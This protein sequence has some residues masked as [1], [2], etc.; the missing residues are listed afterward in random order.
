M[1][2]LNKIIVFLI[3]FIFGNLGVSQSFGAPAAAINPT[4]SLFDGSPTA[5]EDATAVNGTY[6]RPSGSSYTF[7]IK[8]RQFVASANATTVRIDLDLKS[9]I[10][11]PVEFT[12]SAAAAPA[13]GVTV[14]NNVTS[15]IVQFAATA[16]ISPAAVTI[17]TIT[18]TPT[19]GGRYKLVST[20]SVTSGSDTIAGA[21]EL[22]GT[23]GKGA[24]YFSGTG[25]ITAISGRGTTT[26]TAV[27]GGIAAFKF[28]TILN[29]NTEEYRLFTSGY[30]SIIS[31]SNGERPPAS[32]QTLS[33]VATDYSQGVKVIT[34]ADGTQN[35]VTITANSAFVG[36][37]QIYWQRITPGTLTPVT[38]AIAT[39][40]WVE[41]AS[42]A[43]SKQFSHVHINTGSVLANATNDKSTSDIFCDALKVGV[44]CANI[45]LDL[46]DNLNYPLSMS[47][48]SIV[49]TGPGMA[50]LD[51]TSNTNSTVAASG[52]GLSAETITGGTYANQAV[53]S[54]WPDGTTGI[55][56]FT[57]SAGNNVVAERS[58]IFYG[59]PNSIKVIKQNLSIAAA[60]GTGGVLGLASAN[61]SGLTVTSTPAVTLAVF[62]EKGN[63]VPGVTLEAIP[64]DR[65]V[66]SS[67]T[68]VESNGT[69]A[70]DGLAGPGYYNVSVTP[71]TNGESGS[72]SDVVFRTFISSTGKYVESSPISFSLGGAVDEGSAEF[73]IDKNSFAPGEKAKLTVSLKDKYGYPVYDQDVNIF[74]KSG[75]GPV[76]SKQAMGTLPTNISN[77]KYINGVHVYE[78]YAPAY[79]G[80]FTF[81]AALDPNYSITISPTSITKSNVVGPQSKLKEKIQQLKDKLLIASKKISTASDSAV[82][83]SEKA[84]I[85]KSKT[86]ELADSLKSSLA[87]LEKQLSTLKKQ[88][89][90]I[91]KKTKK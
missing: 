25:G 58:I 47:D 79:E 52:R 41:K 5:T 4:I 85:T 62:D 66:I 67:A 89:I 60:K 46:R 51:A 57:I 14:T 74:D 42:A 84:E 15:L 31:A 56:K 65:K 36:E 59:L 29:T 28:A 16:D 81:N 18:F 64:S 83:A 26:V 12:L 24:M 44:Q 61:P 48:L 53:I 54:I 72:T 71:S 2:K 19:M 3:I 1:K 9:P 90:S 6:P 70:G 11:L 50:G 88:L 75:G 8:Y 55:G 22:D 63:V 82:N 77:A 69:G 32:I 30:G 43:V 35:E 76:F 10:D 39:I 73:V 20:Q 40:N 87:T 7:N 34:T 21:T 23:S 27:K 91:Q 17:G 13:A 33:G 38:I 86:I 80:E 68:F 45:L 78:F 37:Q 49:V